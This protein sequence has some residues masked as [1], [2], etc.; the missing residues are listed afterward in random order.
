MHEAPRLR[1]VKYSSIS[2]R[3]VVYQKGEF[4]NAFWQN[5][6]RRGRGNIRSEGALTRWC[7]MKLSHYSVHT[8][9]C[10]DCEDKRSKPGCNC[11]RPLLIV[12]HSYR[13]GLSESNERSQQYGNSN[14]NNNVL[15]IRSDECIGARMQCAPGKR[16]ACKLNYIDSMYVR[17][18]RCVAL[19]SIKREKNARRVGSVRAWNTGWMLFDCTWK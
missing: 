8:R 13:T 6:T 14:N 15:I 18:R 9:D 4:K 7:V 16:I 19:A 3:R 11:T 5:I 17:R 12:S 10:A 1:R 2:W